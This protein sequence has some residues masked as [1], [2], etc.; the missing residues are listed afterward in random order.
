MAMGFKE[1]ERSAEEVYFHKEE[2]RLLSQLAKRI[3]AKNDPEDQHGS[4]ALASIFR[5]HGVELSPA[6]EKD[7][8]QWKKKDDWVEPEKKWVDPNPIASNHL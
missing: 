1:K 5:K 2:E 3:Q 7:L 8:L 4:K 6:L